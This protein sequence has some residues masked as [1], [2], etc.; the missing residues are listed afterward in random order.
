MIIFP[1]VIFLFLASLLVLLRAPA[2]VLWYAAILVTEF[3]WLFIL[4]LFILLL[5]PSTESY[6]WLKTTI[7]IA[8]IIIYSVPI[9]QAFRMS[10][11]LLKG[12]KAAFP[13]HTAIEKV[14]PFHP[15]RM[16]TGIAAERVP[17]TSLIYDEPNELTLHFYPS[18]I[19]GKRPCII[20]IHGGSWAGGHNLQLPELN[21]LLA[22][23]GYH[24]ASIHYRLAPSH[25]YP[26]QL[27]DVGKALNYL[28]S[29]AIA[30][31]L[32][33][34]AFTLL[35]RSAGGQ[36]A[37]SAA[38]TLA[39]KRIK[40]VIA[41]YAPTDMIW[42]YKNRCNPLVL[43][44][45]KVIENYLGGA[46]REIRHK[47]NES[48]PTEKVTQDAPP[49]LL[50]YAENDPLVSPRHGNRLSKKLEEKGV[51]HFA[52]YLPWATHGFD[53]TLNGP[54]GQLSTWTVMQF[55]KTVYQRDNP[56]HDGHQTM[57]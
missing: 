27:H 29:Q 32:D 11:N 15:L 57:L 40:A 39:E 47:Y 30:L 56:D 34:T 14:S 52:L 18:K 28:S 50:L 21:S 10:N 1:L 35:G 24:V 46:L 31:S 49:T 5:W 22:I 33:P 54:G 36:I 23:E 20:I 44:S 19:K 4:V 55:L 45:R 12:F 37:L 25:L 51:K 48:S 42:G 8:A 41:F 53:Y 16:I 26:C 38:Y 2:N 7:G 3:C 9:I 13:G 43:D 17:Y 6:Q